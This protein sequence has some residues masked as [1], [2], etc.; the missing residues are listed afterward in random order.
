MT[1]SSPSSEVREGLNE[2]LLRRL[3]QD[4]GRQTANGVRLRRLL[5]A[6]DVAGLR[7]LFHAFYA[8]IPHQ[9]YAN[10]DIADYEGGAGG[11]RR[12]CHLC[13]APG[14]QFLRRRSFAGVRFPVPAGRFRVGPLLA[15]AHPVGGRP[16]AAGG[17]RAPAI[18]VHGRVGF[19]V[20]GGASMSNDAKWIIGTILVVAGLLSAQIAGVNTRIDDLRAELTTR[21]DDLRAE[22]TTRMDRLEARIDG[23]D[24][25]VRNVE[26]ALAKVDQRLLTIERVVLPAPG[27][28][29]PP[30]P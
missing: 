5:E 2:R 22:L 19:G 26:I 6:D 9:W 25:R 4:G 3:G 13:A 21:I 7:D 10:N 28:P 18:P 30:A 16:E 11:C 14:L 24:E 8:G 23:L 29:A 27:P 1:S 17:G 12:W 15:S 20:H